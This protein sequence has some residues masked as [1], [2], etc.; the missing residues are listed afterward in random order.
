MFANFDLLYL[1]I[2]LVSGCSGLY[3]A[4]NLIALVLIILKIPLSETS[5]LV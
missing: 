2:C 1:V 3:L 4:V 5:Q